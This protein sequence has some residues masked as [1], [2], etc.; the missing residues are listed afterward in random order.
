MEPRLK[1]TFN[2]LHMLNKL[3]EVAYEVGPGKGREDLKLTDD[4]CFIT[5]H[6]IAEPSFPL[7][8]PRQRS[9]LWQL[10]TEYEFLGGGGYE[11]GYKNGLEFDYVVNFPEAEKLRRILATNLETAGIIEPKLASDK[12]PGIKLPEASND[13]GP[14]QVDS[15][16]NVRCNDRRLNLPDRYNLL[17]KFFVNYPQLHKLS[18]IAYQ[19]YPVGNKHRFKTTHTTISKYI[20]DI[21]KILIDQ[22]N[23]V[24][25][26]L[27]KHDLAESSYQLVPV[28]KRKSSTPKSGKKK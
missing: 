17:L 23:E 2:L 21:N 4:E 11:E 6:L 24:K 9:V 26:L 13:F 22:T 10:A 12:E 8:L 15:A 3:L 18:D 20:S 27:V 25:I 28:K 16:G 7:S 5:F 19:L 1:A 14:L